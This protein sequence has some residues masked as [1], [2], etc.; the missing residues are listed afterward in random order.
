M[1]SILDIDLD[2]FEF[3]D[4]PVQRLDELLGWAERPVDAVFDH[5]R[6]ALELWTQATKRS[7]LATPQ[8]ILHVDQH[9][10]MLGERL[11]LNSGNFLFFAMRRWSKC[12]VHWLV[13]M[14][15]DSPRQWLS[16]R[17]WRSVAQRF[18]GSDHLPL[19]WPK[20]DLVTVCTS[21]GFV[22]EA[23]SRQLLKRIG[24]LKEMTGPVA[25]IKCPGVNRGVDGIKFRSHFRRD[26]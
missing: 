1:S 2:Y 16:E 22:N 15:I 9:H 25:P 4:R 24:R 5:H 20:P 7:K 10:D 12:R 26:A 3:L 6:K 23:L 8:F 11:P 19:G 13:D 21:P 14:V 17:A 18:S